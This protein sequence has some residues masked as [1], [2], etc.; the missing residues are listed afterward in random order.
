MPDYTNGKIYEI[1]NII[2]DAIYI[3]STTKPLSSR[4]TSHIKHARRN[5]HNSKFMKH[6]RNLIP[7]NFS[8]RLLEN[9]PCNSLK[10]LE[11]KETEYI[12]QLKPSLNSKIPRIDFNPLNPNFAP[13]HLQRKFHL[14]E[15]AL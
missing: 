6:L 1:Y 10:E 4:M 2:D 12:L 8:I 15:P 3:G 5:K 13:K 9:Y 14:I 7:H 11:M